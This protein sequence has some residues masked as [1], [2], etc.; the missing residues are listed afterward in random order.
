MGLARR[1]EVIRKDCLFFQDIAAADCMIEA[2]AE[3]DGKLHHVKHC[4]S[5]I[6][7]SVYKEHTGS[8]SLLKASQ[9]IAPSDL[10]Q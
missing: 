5:C 1:L 3:A 7:A 9:D 6:Q 2:K 10:P 4:R 8:G